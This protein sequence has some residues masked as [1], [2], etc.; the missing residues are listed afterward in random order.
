MAV[1]RRR[2]PTP[3]TI[4]EIAPCFIVR[5]H[6]GQALA[7]VCFEEEPGQRT[8]AEPLTRDAAQALSTP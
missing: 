1:E 8:A 7:Y 5:D 3:W 2:F 6:N 4:E